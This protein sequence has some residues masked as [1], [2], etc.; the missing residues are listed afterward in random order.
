MLD[1]LL[2]SGPYGAAAGDSRALSLAALEA[3]P[4]GID[5]GPLRPSLAARLC[6]GDGRIE[7]GRAHV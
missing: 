6:T 2:Q 4:H 3:A 5:L 1:L 7:I